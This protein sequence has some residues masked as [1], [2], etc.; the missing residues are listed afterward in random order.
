MLSC[1]NE[2]WKIEKKVLIMKIEEIANIIEESSRK[3]AEE[4]SAHECYDCCNDDC[5]SDT[6]LHQLT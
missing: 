6:V 3:I 1:Y 4:E 2:V 5:C